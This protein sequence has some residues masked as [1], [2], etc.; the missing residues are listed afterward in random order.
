MREFLKLWP[1]RLAGAEAWI[2]NNLTVGNGDL[3]QPPYGRFE[4]NRSA[5]ESALID[6]AGLP[7]RLKPDDPLRGSVR[8]PGMARDEELIP[9]AEFTLPA[10]TR[11]IHPGSSLAPGA[12]Q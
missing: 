10:G 12:F 2:L 8:V 11:P 1:E 9:D 3:Y 7:V 5:P 4:G 6:Y